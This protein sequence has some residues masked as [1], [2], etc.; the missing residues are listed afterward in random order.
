MLKR[1]VLFGVLA[2]ALI[3]G[4]VHLFLLRFEVGDVYPPY[5]TL[6]ADPLGTKAFYAATSELPRFEVRRNYRPIVKLNSHERMTA[7]WVGDFLGNRWTQDD[8]RALESSVKNG[9]RAI[10]AFAPASSDP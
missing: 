2:A 3:Y 6:R 8:L 9:T 4:V 1:L 5:S 10:F 7:I